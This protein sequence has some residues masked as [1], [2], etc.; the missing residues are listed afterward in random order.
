[1][2]VC[3]CCSTFPV[4]CST[5]W[6]PKTRHLLTDEGPAMLRVGVPESRGSGSQNK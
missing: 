5:T 1:M 3:A 6:L 2:S 4:G